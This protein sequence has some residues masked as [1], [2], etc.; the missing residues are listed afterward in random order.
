VNAPAFS[1]LGFLG[2][3]RASGAAVEERMQA[4]TPSHRLH[5]APTASETHQRNNRARQSPP[6]GNFRNGKGG[7]Q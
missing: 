2:K 6:I 7:G 1:E 5:E 3:P 4:A